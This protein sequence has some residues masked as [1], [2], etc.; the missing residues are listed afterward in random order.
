[1]FERALERGRLILALDLKGG[2]LLRRGEE[3]LGLL[4]EYLVGVKLN[5]HL[6]IPLGLD[7]LKELNRLSR[8]LGLFSVADLKLNDVGST[9]SVAVERL[10]EAGFDAVIVNPIA[11][12]E[13]GLDVVVERAH[14]AGKGVIGLAY[15]SHK[16]ARE[17]YEADVGGKKLYRL[18]LERARD[19]GLDGVVVGAARLGVIREA[20][21]MGL[22]V[23]SPGAITQGGDPLKAVEAGADFIIIGRAI[24]N[25]RDPKEEAR[26]ISSQL[27]GT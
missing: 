1:M 12:F 25:S 16:G 17:F 4:H 6:I 9:N 5:L 27:A 2:D 19:W 7:E 23:F 11:G 15:M 8:E 14:E 21:G 26:R 22:T 24:L 13:D 20:K 3:I 18:F 10:W